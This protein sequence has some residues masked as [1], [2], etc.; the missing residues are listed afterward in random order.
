MSRSCP[1][2]AEVFDH[3][4]RIL[5]EL[6]ELVAVGAHLLRHL[7]G[8]V[9]HRLGADFFEALLELGRVGDVRDLDAVDEFELRA[10]Q[11]LRGAVAAVVELA[12]LRL[13]QRDEFSDVLRRVGGADGQHVGH[14]RYRRDRREVFLQV[15]R[16]LLEHRR[17][18]RVV[19]RAH[20]Q[21]VAVGLAL[22]DEVGAE[23]GTGAG[24][25]LDDHGL[26][27]TGCQ[28]LGE[29]ARQHLGGA[30]GR[31]GHDEGDRLVRPRVCVGM[32]GQG[33]CVA[34]TTARRVK[35]R[36]FMVCLLFDISEPAV[37]SRR[38]SRRRF[39]PCRR[40]HRCA[41]ICRR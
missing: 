27:E 26:A 5:D 23:R 24:L 7:L 16:Q 32:G 15:V 37:R 10:D 28:L 29:G 14:Q 25:A 18:N 4:L 17:C 22:G 12:R 40:G 31:E 8:R 20:Q 21:R 34:S 13:G 41:A 38:V 6:G 19:H 39:S 30:A 36:R 3:H 33:Q 11:V 9:A 2:R 35:V 1:D